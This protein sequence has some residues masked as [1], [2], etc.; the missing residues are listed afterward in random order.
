[1]LL[2]FSGQLYGE[3]A[4]VRFV[5]RLRED[6]RFDSVEDLVAQTGRDVDAVRSLLVG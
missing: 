6:R 5:A 3:P 1:Y 4:R 2:G